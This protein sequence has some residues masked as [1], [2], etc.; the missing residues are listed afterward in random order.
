MGPLRN[1]Y[2][3]YTFAD[4]TSQN[5]D[6][7]YRAR[8]AIIALDGTRTRSQR[9]LDLETFRTKEE[10]SARVQ[11]AAIAWI[12]ADIGRDRLALPTN[13]SPLID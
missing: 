10:A 1:T 5:E 13:F 8:A 7:R 3:G 12:D 11:A 6:G 2:K 4:M 9:F